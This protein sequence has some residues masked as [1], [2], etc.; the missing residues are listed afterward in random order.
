MSSKYSSSNVSLIP[1]EQCFENLRQSILQV[2]HHEQVSDEVRSF[3]T[4]LVQA[5]L[6]Y[7]EQTNESSSRTKSGLRA[8]RPTS[9]EMDPWFGNQKVGEPIEDHTIRLDSMDQTGLY[10]LK[11]TP[12]TRA[13]QVINSMTGKILTLSQEDLI[14]WAEQQGIDPR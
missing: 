8:L 10:Q 9:P 6:H 5:V 1:L 11:I 13:I 4:E 14:R 7:A 3:L 12:Q 2:I